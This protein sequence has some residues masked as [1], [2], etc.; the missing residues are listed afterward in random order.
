M[1]H[2]ACVCNNLKFIRGDWDKINFYVHAP[3]C[4]LRAIAAV[5]VEVAAMRTATWQSVLH[6]YNAT[7]EH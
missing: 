2:G 7:L 5:N 4:L 3:C 1:S 6:P